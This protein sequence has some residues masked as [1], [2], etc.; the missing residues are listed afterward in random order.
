M[1]VLLSELV[2]QRKLGAVS[3]EEYLKKIEELAKDIQP[4]RS[5][6]YPDSIDSQA[7]RALYDNLGSNEILAAELFDKINIVRPDSWVGTAIKEKV[8]R[9]AIREILHN[10]GIIDEA[11]VT[12]VFELATNQAEFK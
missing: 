6:N 2:N 1:S 7:K 8:V 12:R 4:K 10:H 5:N 3:Y 11:E 9:N